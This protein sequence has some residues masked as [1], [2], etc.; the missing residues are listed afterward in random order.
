MPR[1]DR[2]PPADNYFFT[3]GSPNNVVFK[4]IHNPRRGLIL[5]GGI[6]PKSHHWDTAALMDRIDHLVTRSEDIVWT[7]SSSPRTPRETSTALEA[8]A[9]RRSTVCFYRAE[10]TPSG[11]IEEQYT[12]NERVWVTADSIS[13]IF[14]A[15]TA[16]C[17]V[18]VLPVRWKRK[19]NKFQRS[20]DDLIAEKRVTFYPTWIEQ[21]D[22][23]VRGKR[24]NEA[25]R[26]AKELLKRWW[27]ER[28]R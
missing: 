20:I 5:V 22:P 23:M 24:L 16:G 3:T 6:D 15:L 26:C 21:Q 4:T 14:E 10:E 9:A 11:W 2:Q 19:V 8:M 13:M 25:S 12:Q 17:R 28:L 7:V 27:P 1:H 18:G